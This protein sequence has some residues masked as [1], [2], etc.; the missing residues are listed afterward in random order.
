MVKPSVQRLLAETVM[1]SLSSPAARRVLE[2]SSSQ[3]IWKLDS[4]TKVF[5]LATFEKRWEYHCF[6]PICSRTPGARGHCPTL[7][8]VPSFWLFLEWLQMKS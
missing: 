5:L 4:E 3:Q 1:S 8:T 2:L 7:V 6:L